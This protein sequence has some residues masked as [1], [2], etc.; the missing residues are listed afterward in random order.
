MVSGTV[1]SGVRNPIRH[2]G[3]HKAAGATGEAGAAV[4]KLA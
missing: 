3:D 1:D 4:M 2:R